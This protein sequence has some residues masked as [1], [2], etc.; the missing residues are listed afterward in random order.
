MSERERERERG[1]GAETFFRAMSVRLMKDR[2][3][4]YYV[5]RRVL[6]LV[7][8]LISVC[9][10]LYVCIVHACYV[11]CTYIHIS[12]SILDLNLQVFISFLLEEKIP[13]SICL[14]SMYNTVCVVQECTKN[15]QR[16]YKVCTKN[17]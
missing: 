5:V 7:V 10:I 2:L 15:V 9:I 4:L 8:V 16:M 11:V 17:V 3:S 13:L 1:K 6:I 12:K 14:Y